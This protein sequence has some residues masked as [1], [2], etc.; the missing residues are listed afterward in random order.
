MW[1]HRCKIKIPIAVQFMA[2]KRNVYF[3]QSV[4]LKKNATSVEKVEIYFR[5]LFEDDPLPIYDSTY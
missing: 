5:I 3:F 4:N 2:E 1:I